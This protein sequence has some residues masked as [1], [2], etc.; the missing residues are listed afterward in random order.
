MAP[1]RKAFLT[2]SVSPVMNKRRTNSR[3]NRRRSQSMPSLS[4]GD[5]LFLVG[6][7]KQPF[8]VHSF[9]L[10]IVSDVFRVFFTPSWH[11][12]V[13]EINDVEPSAFKILMQV[14]GRK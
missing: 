2:T 4:C 9:L 12:D 14:K 8:L 1:N 5:V 3:Q 6:R 13:V 10:T 11:S 7:Q